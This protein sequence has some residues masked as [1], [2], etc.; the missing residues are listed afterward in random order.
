MRIMIITPILFTP[1]SPFNHIFKGILEGFLDNEMYVVRCVA[2]D[3]AQVSDYKMGI[4]SDHI[5]YR[6]YKRRKC[7]KKN[8]VWRFVFDFWT[9]FRMAISILTTR[10]IDVLF[11]DVSYSSIVPVVLAKIKGIRVA[12]MVQ[13]VWPDNA[14]ESKLIGGTGMIYTFFNW[15]QNLVYKKSDKIIVISDDIKE[16]IASKGIDRAKIDVI[17]NWGYSDQTVEIEWDKNIFVQQQCLN[18]DTFYAVYAGN[19][20]KMQNVQVVVEAAKHLKNDADIHFLIIGDGVEKEIIQRQVDKGNLRNIDILPMQPPKLATSI[21]SMAGVNI[22]PL[23]RDGINT[24]LPSKTGICLSCGRP[25]IACVGV[26]TQ[27]SKIIKTY[28]AGET[29]ESEDS[30]QLAQ[31]IIKVKNNNLQYKEGTYHCFQQYFNRTNNIKKYSQI[32]CKLVRY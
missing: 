30:L 6:E 14:V 25:I 3:K 5:E 27:F 11:E 20:G 4:A 9:N 22:I 23:V 7:N 19:I 15:L 26:N 31:A 8:F 10:G 21:Y 13:D 2:V 24:A 17:Y 18:Q 28:G 1:Q 12:S 16:F 29:V 32:I